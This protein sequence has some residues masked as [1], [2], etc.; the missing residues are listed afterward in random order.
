MDISVFKKEGN[1]YSC[2][3]PLA[4]KLGSRSTATL[5]CQG[6]ASAKIGTTQKYTFAVSPISPQIA[7]EL[8][9]SR[10]LGTTSPAQPAV[11]FDIEVVPTLCFGA[12]STISTLADV[13]TVG[14]SPS[15]A[16]AIVGQF[17]A[18]AEPDS[19]APRVAKDWSLE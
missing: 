19:Y 6:V 12:A 17:V 1:I 13:K 2:Q 14:I 7:L 11:Y 16:R 18:M 5:H 3:F 8:A 15:Q 4:H 10:Y 9:T